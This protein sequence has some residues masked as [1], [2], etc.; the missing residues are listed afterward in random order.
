MLLEDV[1]ITASHNPFDES[2]DDRYVEWERHRGQNNGGCVTFGA[3][4]NISLRL[5]RG[6]RGRGRLV[7]YVKVRYV[8]GKREGAAP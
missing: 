6:E 7:M 5:M 1:T 8:Q 3:W 4:H 2:S